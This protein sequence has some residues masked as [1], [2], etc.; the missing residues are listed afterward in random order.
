MNKHTPGPWTVTE[1]PEAYKAPIIFGPEDDD[2]VCCMYGG[3]WQVVEANA[4]LIAAAP[5]LLE[6]LELLSETDG[7]PE[8]VSSAEVLAARV[9]AIAIDAISKATQ[10]IT[11]E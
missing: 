1:N 4:Q 10:P 3:Q 2:L 5:E 8:N 7:S 9:R 11:K 6:A